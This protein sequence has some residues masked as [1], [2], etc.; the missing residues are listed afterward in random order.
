M[1]RKM[2]TGLF[3]ST[4]VPWKPSAILTTDYGYDLEECLEVLS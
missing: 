2:L 3:R 4:E 1:Q